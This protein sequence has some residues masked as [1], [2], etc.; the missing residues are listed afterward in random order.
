MKVLQKVENQIRT[1]IQKFHQKVFGE[2]LGPATSN[3]MKNLSYVSVSFLIAA[4]LSMILQT[5]AGRLLGPSDYGILSVIRSLALFLLIPLT[6][7]NSGLVKYLAQS[8]NDQ[9]R[10]AIVSISILIIIVMSIVTVPIAYLAATYLGELSDLGKDYVLLAMLLALAF[11]TGDL[12]RRLSQGL[13]RMKM[14]SLIELSRASSAFAIIVVLFTFVGVEVKFVV[15]AWSIGQIIT[16]MLMIPSLTRYFRLKI[17]RRWL[18]TL[19]KYGFYNLVGS[20]FYVILT[21]ADRI[22]I[23]KFINATQVGIYQAYSFATFGVATY[24][25]IIFNTVFFPEASKSNKKV[26]WNKMKRGMRLAPLIY[27]ITLISCVVIIRLYGG[28]Y[29]FIL[30]LVM[31]FPILCTVAFVYTTYNWFSLS[32]GINGIRNSAIT[33]MIAAGVDISLN[34]ILLP[35]FGILGAVIAVTVAYSVAL[36]VLIYRTKKLLDEIS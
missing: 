20:A 17:D 3:F 16:L 13:N 33:I 19:V 10:Q 34:I 21:N 2:D 1:L 5:Y 7:G 15:I 9:D 31:I 26:V 24:M 25:M 11:V 4:T 6:L 28:E 8:K 27:L 22:L 23:N 35:V 12:S 14:V 36:P 29:P 30:E 32:L 18:P